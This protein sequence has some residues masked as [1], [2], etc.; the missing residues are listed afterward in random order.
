MSRAG[1]TEYTDPGGC[2]GG[3]MSWDS[4]RARWHDWASLE[5]IGLFSSAPRGIVYEQ[6]LEA[7]M[8]AWSIIPQGIE[9]WDLLQ[10]AG[11]NWA[12]IL[13]P[14]DPAVTR[15][16]QYDSTPGVTW[17][18]AWLDDRPAGSPIVVSLYREATPKRENVVNEAL[19]PYYYTAVRF[20]GK[21]ELRL[22][23]WRQAELW[24]LVGG[25]WQPVLRT[26]WRHSEFYNDS[27]SQQELFIVIINLD[28]ML[29]IKNSHTEESVVYAEAKPIALNHPVIEVSGNGGACYVGI[30]DLQFSTATDNYLVSRNGFRTFAS[31]G[32]V[33]E[34]RLIG[35]QG[36][37]CAASLKL[38]DADGQEWTEGS[39]SEYIMDRYGK[40]KSDK[41]YPIQYLKLLHL[42]TT[43]PYQTPIVRFAGAVHPPRADRVARAPE[44]IGER[45][46]SVQGGWQVDLDKRLATQQYE[47]TL[48][49]SDGHFADWTQDRVL[50]LRA[51]YE[52]DAAWT[53]LGGGY[54][55]VTSSE[56]QNP[57]VASVTARTLDR[58]ESLGEIE[59]GPRAPQDGML[60]ADALREALEWGGV[61][62]RT[63]LNAWF[64][65]VY[66][67]GTWYESGR[68]IPTSRFAAEQQLRGRGIEAAASGDG[69]RSAVA[70]PDPT[71]S[72]LDYLVYLMQFDV[73][74]LL[75]YYE[76]RFHYVSLEEILES[77][78]TRILSG[79]AVENSVDNLLGLGTVPE[80]GR[81]AARVMVVGEDRIYKRPLAATAT[82]YGALRDPAARN[83][84]GYPRTRRITDK[85]LNTRTLVSQRCRWEYEKL[86]ALRQTVSIATA[87]QNRQMVLQRVTPLDERSGAGQRSYLVIG[88]QDNIS[89]ERVWR[90]QIDA[91]QLPLQA[92]EVAAQ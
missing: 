2:D 28:G 70:Q 83:F 30:H 24:K 90:T 31:R 69:E 48:D 60:V 5:E 34:G 22:P 87:G 33:P 92:L 66:E 35:S 47:L 15:Y 39:L 42:E 45:V 86:R 57:A 64:D 20:G 73:M 4:E 56:V 7:A 27:H 46:L 13:P 19:L 43:N 54:G 3:Y 23:K 21:Y 51:R 14:G 75:Y 84:V 72:V 55:Y 65:P 9:T 36:S 25:Q 37:E 77:A 38:V 67:I 71:D 63:T 91:A 17:R 53:E 62:L 59:C 16:H 74:T 52:G 76:G 10:I 6:G 44:E 26:P 81:V 85:S 12:T 78:E 32:D 88:V 11:G 68:R 1:Y 41:V 29:L 58:L 89:R 61:H 79:T 49:N 80:T 82:D 18:A 50:E 8:L 40:W